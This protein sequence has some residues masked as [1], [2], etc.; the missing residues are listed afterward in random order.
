[1]DTSR[2]HLP[3][4]E[5]EVKLPVISAGSALE[6]LARAG[7][8]PQHERAFE[9]NTVF[10]TPGEDLMK[11]ARLLRLREFR[12]ESIITFKG[13]PEPGLHK[14]R[15]EI[16]TTAADAGKMQRILEGLG[17]R[18]QFRYEKYRTTFVRGNDPG[19]AVLD[20]TPIGTFLELEG[21]PAWIDETAAGMGFSAADYIVLSYGTLY[22]QHCR[23]KNVEPANMVFD[24]P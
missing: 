12:G 8:Q 10:D 13:E 21:P 1:M 23:A 24:Q 6:K 7:F 9:A 19:H 11:S 20:E 18:V 2:P 22:R 4:K 15:P 16:E 3:E 14:T 5:T 17:Y